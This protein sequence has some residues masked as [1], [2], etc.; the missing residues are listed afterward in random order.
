[1]TR[2]A[3]FTMLSFRGSWF[4]L[5]ALV[6][7]LS[8]VLVF[9][10][11]PATSARAAAA[12][13]P[14]IIFFIADDL[15]VGDVRYLRDGFFETPNI[16]RLAAQSTRFTQAYVTAAVCSPSRAALH[17]GRHQARFG[18]DFN[19]GSAAD[20]VQMALPD[21]ERT[22]AE[23]L[24]ASGYRTGLIGK[25]HLENSH[26]QSSPLVRG[27]DYYFGFASGG[28]YILNL[29]DGDQV[30]KIEGERE[31]EVR[32]QGFTRQG[33]RVEIDGYKTDVITDEAVRYIEAHRAADEP[34][35]LVVAH[36]APHVPLEAT[37]SYLERVANVADPMHRVY[38]AMVTALD[39]GLG[40]VLDA[41]DAA[42]AR[43]PTMVVF[44]SDNGCPEYASA[45]CSNA[46][47]SGFKRELREG[48][49][50]TPL[51]IRWV[52]QPRTVE[53]EFSR[54][55]SSLDAVASMVAAAGLAPQL[56]ELDGYDLLPAVRKGRTPRERFF[57]R[58]GTDY[59]V[60]EGDWKLIVTSDAV[61]QP[62]RFLFNLADD[63]KESRNV[64]ERNSARAQALD[65][66]F[67]RWNQD[68]VESRMRGRLHDSRIAGKDV[69][70]RY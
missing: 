61:G 54:P 24:K 31:R 44:L 17:T 63:P 12:E 45:A 53:R 64:V 19:P 46:P 16:D 5:T 66:A 67:Q 58:A 40:K 57:W 26:K 55:V 48:G 68:N 36:H 7:S 32:S 14:N 13:Q 33:E 56:G 2:R 15:G 9:V 21:A 37:R 22:I 4:R 34:Y 59:A 23:R 35:F 49:L 20:I 25:W 51:L 39:D 1:M 52:G 70:V 8:A 30:L 29:R 28:N 62:A 6:G 69:K 47:Y 65:A 60:R 38:A 50:H 11:S 43:R 42:S 3:Q 18:H 27:F 10:A 41:A